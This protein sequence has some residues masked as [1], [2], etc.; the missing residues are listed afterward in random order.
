[1]INILKLK[2]INIFDCINKIKDESFKLGVLESDFKYLVEWKNNGLDNRIQ[3]IYFF[4]RI[5]Y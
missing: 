4:S 1:M 3:K 2:G 5:F